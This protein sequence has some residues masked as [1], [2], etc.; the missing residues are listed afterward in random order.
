MFFTKF[1]PYSD[2]QEK[3]PAKGAQQNYERELKEILS[4]TNAQKFGK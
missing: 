1:C 3:A 4:R 2:E